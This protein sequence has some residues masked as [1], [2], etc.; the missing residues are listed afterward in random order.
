MGFML[1]PSTQCVLSSRNP[2]APVMIAGWAAASIAAAA[3]QLLG[4]T[5]EG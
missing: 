3:Q 1:G 2:E 4:M 5:C